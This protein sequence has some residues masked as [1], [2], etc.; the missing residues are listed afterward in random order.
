MTRIQKVEQT[1][2]VDEFYFQFDALRGL[3]EVT[4]PGIP[5][6]CYTS[7]FINGLAME[8]HAYVKNFHPVTVLDANCLALLF[9]TSCSLTI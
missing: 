3:I 7:W 9:D 1:T 5:E 8:V 2:T 4:E 6:S